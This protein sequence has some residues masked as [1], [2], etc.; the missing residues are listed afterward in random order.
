MQS[1]FLFVMEKSI[2]YS[3]ITVSQ[4]NSL[5]TQFQ[6]LYRAFIFIVIIMSKIIINVKCEQVL[7]VSVHINKVVAVKSVMKIVVI[8]VIRIEQY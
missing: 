2:L 5:K 6:M 3:K 1:Q 4:K 8:M 7:A